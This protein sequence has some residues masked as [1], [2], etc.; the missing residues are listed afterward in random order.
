MQIFPQ[1]D[2]LTS[3]DALDLLRH[4]CNTM[5]LLVE[6]FLPVFGADLEGCFQRICDSMTLAI[7]L[8]SANCIAGDAGGNDDAQ[9]NSVLSA[10]LELLRAFVEKKEARR[11]VLARLPLIIGNLI[12]LSQVSHADSQRWLDD[13]DEFTVSVGIK[14]FL[15]STYSS[16]ALIRLVLTNRTT[17]MANRRRRVCAY[18]RTTSSL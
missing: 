9:L 6:H 1:S 3:A 5:R 14:Y 11:V 12:E 15:N 16:Y 7:G 10:Y 8:Y 2:D 13:L 17:R 4:S 18:S